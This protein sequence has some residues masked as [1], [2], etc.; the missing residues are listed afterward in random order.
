MFRRL[1][2]KSRTIKTARSE[3]AINLAAKRGYWPLVKKVV[4]SEEIK[5]KFAILQHEK[6][7]EIKVLGD[8]RSREGNGYKMIIDFTWYYLHHFK[9]PFAAYLIPKNLKKGEKVFLE[10]LIEDY[11]GWCWNQGDAY[12]LESSEAIWNG[13]D[14]EILKKQD[15]DFCVMG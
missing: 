9:S 2:G 7:G 1:L 10:D 15:E 8:Y 5:T 14:F 13:T 12:R 4:P 6:T 3:V 11:V